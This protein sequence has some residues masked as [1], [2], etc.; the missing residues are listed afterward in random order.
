MRRST[1]W[2]GHVPEHPCPPSRSRTPKESPRRA[3]A[4]IRGL[5]SLA[6][7][8]AL[9]V[10]GIFLLALPAGS[11]RRVPNTPRTL[12][13]SSAISLLPEATQ[14]S[15]SWYDV[16]VCLDRPETI[17]SMRQRNPN[18]RFLWNI[19]PQFV[20]PPS[21]DNPWWVADTLWSPG[22]LGQY[23]VQKND[24]Y[25]RDTSGELVTNGTGYL[26]NWTRFC[27]VGTYGTSKGLR[28]SEWY[29]SV[30]LP[31]IALSGRYWEPWSWVSHNS[32]NGYLFE[33]L[34]DCLGSYGWQYYADCD[35]N[36]DGLADGVY[37]ACSVGGADDPLSVLFRGEND[38]FYARLAA[39]FPADFVFL[40][41]E[42]NKYIGPW[43]RTRMSGM[44]LENWMHTTNP[45][46]MD[47]WDWFYGLTPPWQPGEN[48]GSGYAW[49]ETAFDKAAPDSL[50]G[51]D[52]SFVQVW[53]TP[54]R[55]EESNLRQM[56]WGLG[57]SMLGDGL[58]SY[59]KDQLHPHWQ[60]E[61][62]W[63]FGHPLGPFER[64]V[65]PNGDTLYVRLFTRGMVEVNPYP[66]GVYGVAP[67]D[68]RFTFWSPVTDLAATP[69]DWKSVRVTWT[70]PDGAESDPDYF[71][72]RYATTPITEESFDS[73][74][75]F[76]RNP[77]FGNPGSPVVAVME[78][79]EPATTY[80]I[81]IR[82][83]TNGRAEPFISPVVS[84]RTPVKPTG[85]QAPSGVDEIEAGNL[86]DRTNLLV[87]VPN[88]TRTEASIGFEI[89]RDAGPV[90]VTIHDVGG[91]LVRTLVDGLSVPG[92]HA[93]SWDGHDALGA[94]VGA[95]LYFVRMSWP[96]GRDN[97]T[98]LFLK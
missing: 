72:L 86:P 71:E 47:W 84:V 6:R 87:I 80:S 91:R 17:T 90:R 5:S 48:W 44:K 31:Q 10:A 21:G 79:L 12:A 76:A 3:K 18:L 59:T 34:A 11:T 16:L 20:A 25:M 15:L 39:A 30:L 27:P 74:T 54:D 56:R 24:W 61:F 65:S 1:L 36:R 70:A 2:S 63:D 88:P 23:Y 49:A 93:R 8:G 46:W 57:T 95:G 81:A 52:L 89:S 62:D 58:F 7:H 38:V 83:H 33:I 51:W 94:R 43:W 32:Y 78:G 77:V 4:P 75:P 41:N 69:I 13:F 22:R 60:R 50:K 68:G 92:R 53:D 19:S 85:N 37:H 82:T 45:D 73:A 67:E 9:I 98:L 96:G 97:A 28:A 26:V 66:W 14:D 35:P 40:I 55:T 42:N 29:A 64:D